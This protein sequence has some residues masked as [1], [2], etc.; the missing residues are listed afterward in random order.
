[1]LTDISVAGGYF[2]TEILRSRGPCTA[3]C[4]SQPSRNY[5][6][7]DHETVS[8]RA[9]GANQWQVL[10]GLPMNLW[11]PGLGALEAKRPEAKR[12]LSKRAPSAEVSWPTSWSSLSGSAFGR[13]AGAAAGGPGQRCSAVL[14]ISRFAGGLPRGADCLPGQ[15]LHCAA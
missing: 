8:C 3:S 9:A 5:T 2:F 13:P 1:M 10:I 14:R 11:T 12:S 15:T 6:R 7:L 4:E